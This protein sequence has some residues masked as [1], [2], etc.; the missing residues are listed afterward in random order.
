MEEKDLK[1]T[2]LESPVHIVS[3]WL[4]ISEEIA[5]IHLN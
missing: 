5:V 2:Q 3:E 4:W 1:V